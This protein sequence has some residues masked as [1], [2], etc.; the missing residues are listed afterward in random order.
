MKKKRDGRKFE[1]SKWQPNLRRHEIEND[2]VNRIIDLTNWTF[3]EKWRRG[4]CIVF[5]VNGRRF[6]TPGRAEKPLIPFDLPIGSAAGGFIIER[7]VF[8]Q[9]SLIYQA[10]S[11]DR[12]PCRLANCFLDLWQLCSV[13]PTPDRISHWQP[14]ANTK[15][16]CCSNWKVRYD[17]AANRPR[18]NP[19]WKLPREIAFPFVKISF[20][21]D[22]KR[23]LILI[24]RLVVWLRVTPQNWFLFFVAI[25]FCLMLLF[26]V[27]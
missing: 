19:L 17:N 18:Y 11:H 23:L 27:R 21:S 9:N 16:R 1:K 25:V 12:S 6:G 20:H 15:Y 4:H 24:Y 14:P 26:F 22:W 5:H 7:I 13:S 2:L 3:N 8:R 10:V